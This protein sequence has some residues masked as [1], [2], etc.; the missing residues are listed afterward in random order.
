M[1]KFFPKIDYRPKPDPRMPNRRNTKKTTAGHIIGKVLKIKTKE[2]IL[3]DPETKETLHLEEQP[4]FKQKKKKKRK[5]ERN[6]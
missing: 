3:K 6:L 2:K 1:A 5:Q 4:H